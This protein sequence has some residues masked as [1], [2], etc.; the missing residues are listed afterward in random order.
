MNS[1]DPVNLPISKLRGLSKLYNLRLRD[2]RQRCLTGARSPK[3]LQL[4]TPAGGSKGKADIVV[5]L[6]DYRNRELAGCECALNI[7]VT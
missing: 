6:S 5:T 3:A 4:A 7:Q 1:N 2:K